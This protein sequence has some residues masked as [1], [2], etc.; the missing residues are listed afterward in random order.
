MSRGKR[1]RNRPDV[2]RDGMSATMGQ[3]PVYR[4]VRQYEFIYQRILS[5]LAISRFKW[6]GL[7]PSI[8]E[9]FLE[10][11]LH[12]NGLIVFYFDADYDRF[13]AL[14]GTGVG[15]WNMYDNPTRFQVV[16]NDMVHKQLNAKE[17]VP[18][19][20]N[21][22]RHPDVSITDV[23][24]HRLAEADRT[25]DIN[26]LNERHPWI[27]SVNKNERLS[28]QAAFRAVQEG[29]PVIWGTDNFTPDELAKKLN[30]FN[31]GQDREA[32]L[33][34]MTARMRL[35]NDCMTLLGIEN[36]NTDKRERMIVDEVNANAG[37]VMA[38]R[39]VSMIARQEAAR[40]INRL[41]SGLNVQVEWNTAAEVAG[42]PNITD[43]GSGD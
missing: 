37:Q 36:T 38:A 19:W 40:Q 20:S 30:V 25:I 15:K 14:R 2:I 17:C 24:A 22:L 41:W 35:W 13:L 39:N 42:L 1:D 28:L 26:L 3:S 9:R 10:L 31:V 23:Y 5:E 34:V 8:D 7:P 27:V 43:T 4:G 18:I 33:N 29:Q 16:G 11:T 32:T 21:Y 6:K 12:T